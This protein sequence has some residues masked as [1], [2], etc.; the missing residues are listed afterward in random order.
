MNIDKI[1][2]YL[3]VAKSVSQ[4]S[5]DSET[6]VGSIIVKDGVVISTGYN[7][8]L[9]KANDNLLPT[10]RPLKYSYMIHSEQNAIYNCSRVGTSLVGCIMFITLSP[11]INCLRAVFQSGIDVVYFNNIH[12]SFLE[13]LNF[14]DINISMEI[15]D[16]YIR[17]E[18]IQALKE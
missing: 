9:R 12:P 10:T 17:L 4:F 5:P 8:F 3:N 16:E 15:C 18:R 11:C 7:G 6:K 2:K 1:Q 13:T 14:D